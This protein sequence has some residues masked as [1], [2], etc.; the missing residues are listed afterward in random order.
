MAPNFGACPEQNEGSAGAGPNRL[1][2]NAIL[3]HPEEPQATKDLCSSLKWQLP[4]FFA[5]LR[6]AVLDGFSAARKGLRRGS[7]LGTK[8]K[9]GGFRYGRGAGPVPAGPALR[10]K[11][12]CTSERKIF[13]PCDPGV[14]CVQA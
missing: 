13:W 2:K 11:P 1:R 6:M 7:K 14:L 8:S 4:R 12:G 9:E 5:A 3:C 10:A